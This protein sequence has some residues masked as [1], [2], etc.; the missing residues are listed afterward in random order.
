MKERR[1]LFYND[2]RHS[3]I[4]Y[5][6][7]PFRLE[8]AWKPI[9]EIVGTG[10]DT[11]VYGFGAGPTMFHNTKVGEVWGSHLE[12]FPVVAGW[13][14]HENIK[15]LNERGLDPLK[16]LIDRAHEKDIEF[17]VSLRQ[18]HQADPNDRSDPI[19]WMFNWQFRIDHPEWCL[20]GRGRHAFDWSHP[21][22]RAE[23]FALI[24]ETVNEYDVD[25]FEIDWTYWPHY[26]E[27]GEAERKADILTEYMSEV[28]RAVDVASERKGRQISLGARILPTAGGNR[29]AGM[30]VTSWIERGSLDF[31]VPMVYQDRQIDADLPFEWVVDVAKANGCGVYASLQDQ[32]GS[33]SGIH[34]G[35]DHYRGAAAA[36]WAKGADGVYLPWFKWPHG[37]KERD[38][39]G[40]I[41]DPMLLSRGSKHYVVRREH[42]VSAGQGY[43]AQLP[44]KIEVGQEER[45]TNVSFYVAD[46]F[47]TRTRTTLRLTLYDHTIHDDMIVTLNDAALPV[48][49]AWRTTRGFTHVVLDFALEPGALKKGRNHVSVSIRTRPPNLGAELP[50]LDGVEALVEY[51]EPEDFL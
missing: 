9:D 11:L 47:D 20:K 7:P 27:D 38:L 2:A 26:F 35:L 16:V 43:G 45:P 50:R 44:A 34:A 49:G 15:S 29:A 46:E 37:D 10:V 41:Q 4:Y 3:Y 14:A 22:V 18:S 40:R 6:D 1:L 39:L 25:G 33:D 23:R 24:E 17:F 51:P 42:E 19:S 48:S 30:D 13:R 31:V 8:D 36:Q 21:E 5:Y 28:R 32:V 12:S